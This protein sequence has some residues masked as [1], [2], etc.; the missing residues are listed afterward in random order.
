MTGAKQFTA[1][2]S[3]LGANVS[4]PDGIERIPQLDASL[5]HVEDK[6]RQTADSDSAQLLPIGAESFPLDII[7]GISKKE[8]R[9]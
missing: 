1:T 3:N 4:S 5:A 9:L 7:L 2:Y 6:H 8:L